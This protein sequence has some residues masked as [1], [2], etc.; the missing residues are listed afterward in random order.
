MRTKLMTLIVAAPLT[1]GV[2]CANDENSDNNVIVAPAETADIVGIAQGVDE[3]STLV[4][5]LQS[6]GLAEALGG[7]GPF[8]VFA[9]VNSAFD[10]I[11]AEDLAALQA[12]PEALAA[13]LQFHV[14]SGKVSAADVVGLTAATTLQGGE[15]SIRVVGDSVVLTDAQGNDVNVTTTD[16]EASNGIVHLIDG[17]LFPDAGEDTQPPTGNIVE[18]ADAAGFSALLSAATAVG[19][20][21]TL[22]DGGPFTVFA[23]TDEAFAAL[24]SAVPSNPDLLANVLLHHVVAGTHESAAV[25]GTGSFTTLAN[26]NLA[27]DSSGSPI[28]V[29]GFALSEA[30]DVA[31]SNGVIHVLDE[32]IVP[33]TILEA[34]AATDDLSTLVT[35]VEASSQ[36]VQDTLA[37]A[38][39]LT[40][41]APVNSAF[42][43]I[44]EGELG[45]LLADQEALDNVLTYHA[46]IGQTLAGDLSDGQKISMANGAELTV[47]IDSGNVALVDGMGNAANVVG[48]DIRVLNGVVHLIDGVLMPRSASNIVETASSAGVF[49][50]LLGAATATGLDS[51]LAE[52]DGLTVFA[53]TDAAFAALGVDLGPVSDAVISNILL[54]H[55]VSGEFASGDVMGATSLTSLANTPLTVD[56]SALTVG[57]AA[58]SSNLDVYASNGIVHVMDAVI[59]PPTIVEVA[60]ATPDLSSLVAAIG[61]AS[62]GVQGAVAPSTL[63]GESPITVFA[64]TN[65]AFIASGIDV[66]SVPQSALDAVLAH[67]VVGAQAVS[68]D[69]VDGQVV[70]TLNG[71]ITVNIDDAGAISITD[72]AGNTANVIA[73]LK[74][75]RTLTG[76]VHVVDAVLMPQ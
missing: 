72:G 59:V 60:A 16:I 8:T 40:I 37:S 23:P 41:F 48:T 11:A 57:G 3:L 65:D 55:V 70:A 36:G 44:D 30:L 63:T 7:D 38:G 39:P 73:T 68:T 69:L 15:I 22:A 62:P 12:D 10:A 53:P 35:A 29:N 25:V 24:G 4:S 6:A 46:A 58:L 71:N 52:A 49:G 20:A 64:P 50:T 13:V 32:V 33:P 76:V 43:A 5:L 21:G 54:S 47:S 18:V 19:L 17:V 75:I 26:T 67:H 31:A 56:A 74:D 34:A 51:A 45:A 14:V 42:A 9:P 28:T 1:F 66:D 27:I 2:A 61:E